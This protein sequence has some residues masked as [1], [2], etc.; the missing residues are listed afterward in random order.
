MLA[1]WY[2]ESFQHLGH[3]KT[4]YW[5]PP[6]PTL[7]PKWY[8]TPMATPVAITQHNLNPYYIFKCCASASKPLEP[9]LPQEPQ[10]LVINITC[11]S[12]TGRETPVGRAQILCG[13]LRAAASDLIRDLIRTLRV[14]LDYFNA[15]AFACLNKPHHHRYRTCPEHDVITYTI[16]CCKRQAI[17]NPIGLNLHLD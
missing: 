16:V 13:K 6:W 8:R 15:P 3:L 7:S 1:D 17:S 14:T 9:R 5:R 12:K 11:K 10:I 4:W 2:P